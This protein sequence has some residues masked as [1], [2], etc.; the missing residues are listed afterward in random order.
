MGNPAGVPPP[1]T[2]LP[3][4]SELEIWKKNVDVQMHF[5]EIEMKV[6]NFL[7]TVILATIGAA[8]FSL[9]QHVTLLAFG[10]VTILPLF[11]L[12]LGAWLAIYMLYMVDRHWYHRLLRGAVEAN[13][14]IESRYGTGT[15]G[16][17]L[18]L[19]ISQLSP[20]KIKKR[21]F[22]ALMVSIG[23]ITETRT[24]SDGSLELPSDGKLQLLYR[25]PM[26]VMLLAAFGS[27]VG[28]VFI[29]NEWWPAA[30]WAN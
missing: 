30:L 3:L 2:P 16:L 7:V 1:P 29:E 9:Q 5:N 14:Q 18:G 26:L 4:G 15:P 24:A 22:I 10:G 6:R 8:G 27:L 13:A 19:K 17:S 28:G 25:L 21:S 11:L 12:F 20:M 23:V